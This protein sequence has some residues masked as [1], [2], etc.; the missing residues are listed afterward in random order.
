MSNPGE[1][2]A[3][4]KGGRVLQGN[5][6]KFSTDLY[7]GTGNFKIPIALPPGR[8]GFNP[9]LSLVC[10][11][12]GFYPL[13]FRGLWDKQSFQRCPV[14]PSVDLKDPEVHL[15]DLDGDGVS[16]AIWSSTR[17]KC[18][19]ND[20][21]R[22]WV[23]SRRVERK[24]LDMFPNMD[25]ADP[26]VKWADMAGDGLQDIVLLHDGLVEYLPSLRRGGCGK[27]IEMPGP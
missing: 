20:A 7:T 4:P 26:P 1:V 3:T 5:G 2:I 10:R 21:E 14:A 17:L 24:A 25:F 15:V 13:G 6:E 23:R 16:D 27:S 11:T 22:G 9:Q 12:G 18:H 8:N 19:F